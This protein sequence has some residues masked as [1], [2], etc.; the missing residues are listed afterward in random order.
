METVTLK[1]VIKM[2]FILMIFLGILLASC[3]TKQE[4]VKL[5]NG[6]VITKKK[7]DRITKK[8]HKDA[9]KFARKAVYSEMSRKQIRQ[10]EKELEL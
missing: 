8:I 5:C 9:K 6:K 3:A 2:K 4:T 10:F 1:K 7:Y